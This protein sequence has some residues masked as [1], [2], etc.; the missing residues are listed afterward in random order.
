MSRTTRRP[1]QA[2][3]LVPITCAAVITCLA[4]ACSDPTTGPQLQ[5]S[6]LTGAA[7]HTIVVAPEGQ[8]EAAGTA[9]APLALARAVAMAPGGSTIQLKAGTYSTPGITIDRPLTLQ[10]APGATV[11]LQASTT[12]PADQWEVSGHLW[13]TPFS[14]AT[15]APKSSSVETVTARAAVRQ[16]RLTIDGKGLAAAGS[17]AAVGTSSFY[18]DTL[19]KWLYVG[20]DPAL[21]AVQ[22]GGADIGVLI[23]APHVTLIGIGVQ[24]FAAIGLRVGNSYAT[25]S[26]GTYSYNSQIGLDVNGVND[27]MIENNA[28][29]HNGQVGVELSHSTNITINANN[30]SNNNTDNY[31]VSQEAAGLKGTNVTNV[32]VKNNWVADNA[33]NAIWFDESSV[34]VVVS[35][36]QVLRNK[37]YAIYFE[38]N[39]GPLIV[40]NVV[41]DNTQAGIG[42]H[43][44]TNAGVYNNT[45]FNNGTDLDVSA[46]YDRSPYDTYGAVIV[47]NIFWD[48]GSLLVNLYR[49]NGCSSWVYKEVDYN[50]YYRSSP[51]NPKYAVNWC[52]SWYSTIGA[53]H[54]GT[55]NEAHGIEYDGGSDPFFVNAWANDFHLHSGS[56]AIKR[57]QGLPSNVAA[58]LGVHAGTAVDM[59]ALQ[60]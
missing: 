41:Y 46:S 48:A 50:A 35:A 23:T 54:S 12:I 42:V 17:I 5:S 59:G 16:Q 22:A 45:L 32:T 13:R 24:T 6:T 29:T 15:L 11:V 38:L 43:F 53:F 9:T 18:V 8:I 7:P 58:I 47:N 25:I 2:R 34:N 36:N 60:N 26:H 1:A 3:A 51:G 31:N 28:M 37:C 55:G 4:A 44:T 30:I 21:H 49:Y 33:S 56:P 57:G 27:V 40:G 39:N 10:A 20:Q 52:N 19:E 14:A